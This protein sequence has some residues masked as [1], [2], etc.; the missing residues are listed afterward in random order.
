MGFRNYNLKKFDTSTIGNGVCL[1]IGKSGTG[2]TTIVKDILHSKPN[3][4]IVCMS[5]TQ[6]GCE[7]YSRGTNVVYSEYNPEIIEDFVQDHTDKDKILVLDDCLYDDKWTKDN[8]MKNVFFNARNIRTACL[9]TMPFPLA[10]PPAFRANV[11]YVFISRENL[12]GNRKRIFEHYAGMFPSFNDFCSVMDKCT[13]NYEC[14][15]IHNGSKSNKFE[16]QVFW[17][18]VHHPDKYKT[19]EETNETNDYVIVEKMNDNLAIQDK[20]IIELSWITRFLLKH[21]TTCGFNSEMAKHCRFSYS[22]ANPAMLK[23]TQ[24]DV[25]LEVDVMGGVGD[26]ITVVNFEMSKSD[27]LEFNKELS[28]NLQYFKN[29][30]AITYITENGKYEYVKGRDDNKKLLEL[31]KYLEYV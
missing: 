10:L 28:R 19:N 2:K 9:L 5:G 7:E 8:V 31:I 6:R 29:L 23:I 15:V 22:C 17:Y 11:D 18:T 25:G 20:N 14:L 3:S 1:I 30:K 4:K 21:K 24:T 26:G 12:I 27:I 16:D 13:E